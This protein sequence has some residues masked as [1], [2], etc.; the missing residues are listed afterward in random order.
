[1]CKTRILARDKAALAAQAQLKRDTAWT[2]AT[3]V[4]DTVAVEGENRVSSAR[5][6]SVSDSADTVG[7]VGLM[8]RAPQLTDELLMPALETAKEVV[9]TAAQE[10]VQQSQT[11]EATGD[12]GNVLVEL[13]RIYREEGI[14]TLFLGLRPRLIYTGLANGIRLAAYGTSRMDL[15]MRS[16]DNI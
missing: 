12:N 15:M 7:P 14:G 8:E 1:M 6:I 5:Y 3:L 16:L 9:C 13:M 10:T 2:P 4:L 11:S